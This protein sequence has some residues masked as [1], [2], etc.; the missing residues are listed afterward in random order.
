MRVLLGSGGLSTELRRMAWVTK[1]DSFLGSVKRVLFVPYA[2]ADYER[3]TEMVKERGLS[4]ARELVG[5]H[6]FPNPRAA[7]ME[8]DAIFVGGGNT[9]RLLDQLYRLDLLTAIRAKVLKGMPYLGISAGSNLAGPTIMTTNDMPIVMPPSFQALSLFPYQ[10]NPHYFSGR[11]FFESEHQLIPYAG[12]TRDDRIR[13]FHEENTTPVIGI[14]EGSWLS[15]VQ[16]R[17][18]LG[19]HEA[20][21]RVFNRG[22]TPRDFA[23]EVELTGL[24]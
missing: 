11:F 10:I 12:E 2:L 23:G 9:F 24:V 22:Q 16:G 8:A 5:I 19:G 4:A 21:A 13:E 7:I 18:H 20:K 14:T 6:K 1:M 15:F 3:Y 17:I